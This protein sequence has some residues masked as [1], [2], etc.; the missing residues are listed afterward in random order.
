M[1]EKCEAKYYRRVGC[2]VLPLDKCSGKRA[3]YYGMELVE[4]LCT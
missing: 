2:H 4:H 1:E 3:P